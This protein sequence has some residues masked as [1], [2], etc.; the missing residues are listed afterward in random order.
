MKKKTLILC[1]MA[2]LLI[3]VAIIIGKLTNKK[4][5]AYTQ[6][7]F[8]LDNENKYVITTNTKWISMQN[9]GGSH[10]NVYYE[11]DLNEN[12]IIECADKY[13]GFKG[14]EYERKIVSTKKIND[15]EKNELKSILND[16]IKKA[17]DKVEEI[18]FDFYLISSF[19][20][21]NIKIYD[22]DTINKIKSIVEND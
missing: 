6:S 17:S 9:D 12:T 3:L 16:A 2:I 7:S 11:I 22:K 13:V 21:E 18:N 8:V 4:E 10:I 14:Y 20:N 15:V 19:D 1:A 5:D